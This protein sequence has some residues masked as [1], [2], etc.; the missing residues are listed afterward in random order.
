MNNSDTQAILHLHGSR[1]LRRQSE[2]R[3]GEEVQT[4][5]NCW[6]WVRLGEH[7]SKVGS[8][9]TPLGGH[10]VYQESGIPLIRSQN[11]H[12]NR[13]EPDGLAFISA[14]QDAEMTASRVEAGDVLLNITGASIGRVCVAPPEFCPANVNQHVCII[15]SDGSFDPQFLA[16]YFA[17]AE[18]Q[19]FIMQAQ[20]G[21]TRQALTKVL[22][23][24]FC[25]P[26][27]QLAEQRRIAGRLREQM[28]DVERARAAVQAQLDAAQ[29]LPAALLRAHFTN[30]ATNRWPRRRL[31][32]L[33]RLRKEVIHPSDQPN[34]RATF[35]GLEHVE[36]RTGQRIGGV[37]LEMTELTGRKPR[38]RAGDIVYG[39]L[40]PYLNKVWVA[41]F[42]GLCSVD[43]YAYSVSSE[44]ADR[45]FVAWFM[46]S[47]TYLERAPVSGSSGQLPRIR[48]EEV[49]AVELNL[50][51]LAEQR[52]IAE[53][54]GAEFASFTELRASLQ[55]RLAEIENLPAAL[56][57]VAFQPPHE[58]GHL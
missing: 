6:R 10:A 27:I 44:V 40:R 8:G 26:L 17:T 4:K 42:D 56:L 47:P 50:P 15:R 38:F 22:V 54:I 37:E 32:D 55:A 43:Q 19:K 41:D 14:E 48:L 18:F 31:G 24:R 12:M 53:A 2:T 51:P 29:A 30:P 20:A 35:V 36:P 11:V 46:R 1:R 9:F 57:R 45:N 52:N 16:F 34:G 33:L 5:G 49:A 28:A 39:Y 13:F 25:V 58:P 3:T 23:E 21:G 7:V